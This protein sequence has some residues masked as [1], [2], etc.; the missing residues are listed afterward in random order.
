M[1]SSHRVAADQAKTE[2]DDFSALSPDEKPRAFRHSLGNRAEI[3]R[4][5]FKL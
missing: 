1:H 2:R 5:R 3:L 4:Q